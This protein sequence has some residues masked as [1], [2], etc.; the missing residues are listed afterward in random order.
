[1]MVIM[2]TIAGYQLSLLLTFGSYSVVNEGYDFYY[3]SD[4]R[5]GMRDGFAIAAA[6]TRYDGS[7][8]DI[9]DEEI[10]MV[11]FFLKSWDDPTGGLR[12][13]ELK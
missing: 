12:F 8:E 6:I 13:K 11:K 5:M 10:G 3:N 2:F 7:E 1:M 4:D 9:E